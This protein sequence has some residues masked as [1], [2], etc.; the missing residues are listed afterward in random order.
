MAGLLGLF[1]PLVFVFLRVFFDTKIS[2]VKDLE[3]ITPIP[4]LG[5]I[6]KSPIESNLVVLTKPK[7]AMAE[8][9]RALR[10]SLQFIHKK[11]GIKG[12]KTVLVTSSVSGEGKT[13]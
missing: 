10:S 9:F 2:N 8:A 11:Q 12:A 5:I 6:G 1:F 13:F 7:S 3:R 4:L